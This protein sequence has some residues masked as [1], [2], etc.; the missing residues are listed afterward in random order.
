MTSPKLTPGASQSF[1]NAALDE[2][3]K[4]SIPSLIVVVIVNLP[5]PMEFSGVFLFCDTS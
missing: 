5:V 2:N 4:T 1:A 3:R